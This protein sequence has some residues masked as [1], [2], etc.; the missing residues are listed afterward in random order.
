VKHAGFVILILS[1]MSAAH[2][3]Q[4]KS[5][6]PDRTA[7]TGDCSTKWETVKP[8]IEY[9]T[10][11][12]IGDPDKVD[13]HLVRVDARKW[14]LDTLVKGNGT[15]ART[16]ARDKDALFAVN[17]NFFDKSRR[18]LGIIVRSG[19]V[20]QKPR[21]TSWQSIFLVSK[22][23]RPRIV[24]PDKWNQH[25]RTAWMA[26]QAGPRLVAEG[27][28]VKLKPNYSAPRVGV[29]IQWDRDL[30]FFATPT[31]QKF[32]VTEM[33]KIARRKENQGGLACRDAMLFDGGHSVNFF[34]G[35]EEQVSIT[36]DPVPV[37]I[38]A[39]ED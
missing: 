11:R 39:T 22:S 16:V 25:R 24:L 19:E 13:L 34:I 26:V 8:D 5:K 4:S 7:P 21:S 12:C 29:C 32:H 38:Y 37:Y 17:A 33:A 28:T 36:G 6:A 10:I 3:Q 15:Y 23:G 9:R 18:P 1:L 2:A 35:G 27:H 14:K 31:T 30:I 20:V